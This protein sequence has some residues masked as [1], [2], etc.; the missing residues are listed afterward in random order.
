MFEGGRM[1]PRELAELVFN[2]VV[3]YCENHSGDTPLDCMLSHNPD[4]FST[5]ASLYLNDEEIGEL[6][7]VEN[8]KAFDDEAEK[9]YAK[10][11][12]EWLAEEIA[13]NLGSLEIEDLAYNIANKDELDNAS[14]VERLKAYAEVLR[15]FADAIK[16]ALQEKKPLSS[17]NL[18]KWFKRLAEFAPSDQTEYI[19]NADFYLDFYDMYDVDQLQTLDLLLQYVN[20]TLRKIE[21][22]YLPELGAL[23]N[24]I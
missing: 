18:Y 19:K 3:D 13:Y 10:L 16:R 1:D 9:E 12:N 15:E 17:A 14:K 11:W 4:E 22:E 5:F 8:P 7:S 6:E 24:K 2:R 23:T 21:N 20:R